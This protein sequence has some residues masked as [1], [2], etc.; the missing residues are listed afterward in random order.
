MIELCN[1]NKIYNYGKSAAVHALKDVNLSISKGDM[2]AITGPSG[3][4]KSTLLHILAGIDTPTSGQYYFN[5][6][7][8]SKLSDREKC[9]L[10]NK[11]IGIILQSFGLLGSETALRN[12]C[13]P[14]IIANTYSHQTVQKA[15]EML[16]VVGLQD[17]AKKP[18]NQLS[19]GQRQRVAI[20]RALTMDAK[21]ILADEPTGALD[22]KNTEA[23]MNL[24]MN[25]NRKGVTML[26]VTHDCY[27]AERCH[28]QYKIVDGML[29][30]E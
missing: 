2:I 5:E 22:T 26:L 12:I 10:R 13:L 9:K 4:G 15:Q 8:I 7:N 29:Y 28:K 25:I 11:E 16:S 3:S 27:V 20:A 23:L 24:L 30:K 18:V 19:G 1:I 21:F 14:H 17:I 6:R